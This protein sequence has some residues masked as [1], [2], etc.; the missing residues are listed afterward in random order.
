MS[1]NGPIPDEDDAVSTVESPTPRTTS[2]SVVG[3][4]S[5]TQATGFFHN[6]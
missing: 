3:E 6:R 4:Y 5:V 2:K 1:K